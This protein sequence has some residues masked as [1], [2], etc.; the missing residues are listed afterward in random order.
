MDNKQLVAMA[1]M[2]NPTVGLILGLIFGPLGLLYSNWLVAIVSFVVI[3]PIATVVIVFTAGFAT[4]L[5]I[6]VAA[7]TNAFLGYY[8]CKKHNTGILSGLETGAVTPIGLK[9]KAA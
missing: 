3:A 2:K 5:V 8:F 4:P 1:N 6:M 7:P 9:K